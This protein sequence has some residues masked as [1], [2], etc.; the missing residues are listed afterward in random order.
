MLQ[1]PDYDIDRAD[2]NAEYECCVAE[3]CELPIEERS[4]S[5]PSDHTDARF[6]SD[7]VINVSWH[8]AQSYCAWGWQAPADRS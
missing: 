4:V 1:L 2:V 8:L 6:A 3:Q 5:H 7:P